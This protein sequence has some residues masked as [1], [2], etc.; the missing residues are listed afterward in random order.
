VSVLV[1]CGAADASAEASAGRAES[2]RVLSD[3]AASRHGLA[4]SDHVQAAGLAAARN[5][6]GLPADA[7][8]FATADAFSG[9]TGALGMLTREALPFVLSP[10][11]KVAESKAF[12]G[13]KIT[14]SA[15][16]TPF[17]GEPGTVVIATSQPYGK[18]ERSLLHAGMKKRD[19]VLRGGIQGKPSYFPFIARAGDDLVILTDDRDTAGRASASSRGRRPDFANAA[20]LALKVRDEA[21]FLGVT[22]HRAGCP[23]AIVA[24]QNVEPLSGQIELRG[25]I[26][27]DDVEIEHPFKSDFEVALRESQRRVD[28]AFE[29]RHGYSDGEIA[30]SELL[31]KGAAIRFSC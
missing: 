13:S 15:G 31:D 25:A 2:L 11:G 30:F 19:G 20:A 3:L 12:D 5:Q 28:I 22:A 1:A 10:F 24:T 16:T 23:R 8:L 17:F 4:Y 27:K 14:A 29:P 6:A 26:H 9:P 18:I 21:P 7:D